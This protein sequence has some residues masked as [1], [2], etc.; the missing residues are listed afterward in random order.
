MWMLPWFRGLQIYL[1][2]FHH[3]GTAEFWRP[4]SCKQ[5]LALCPQWT[6]FENCEHKR[7]ASNYTEVT[8][9]VTG[10]PSVAVCVEGVFQR[11][12]PLQLARMASALRS[13]GKEYLV[14][15]VM[16]GG[17]GEEGQDRHLCKL[18]MRSLRSAFGLK[19]RSL[20]CVVDPTDRDRQFKLKFLRSLPNS[21]NWSWWKENFNHLWTHRVAD[22]VTMA[23]HVQSWT[24]KQMCLQEVVKLERRL[25]ALVDWVIYLRS[26]L[27][28]LAP[29]P[30]LTPMAAMGPGRVWIP[31]VMDWGGL[32]DRWAVMSRDVAPV[33]LGRIR[34]LI[35]GNILPA[36][37]RDFAVTNFSQMLNSEHPINAE[38]ML[39]MSLHYHGI[40]PKR[41]HRFL[42][43]AALHCTAKTKKTLCSERIF[44]ALGP[45]GW[46]DS[47]EFS[48]AYAAASRLQ[49]GWW[50]ALTSP[51]VS[52]ALCERSR[53]CTERAGLG[54]PDCGSSVWSYSHCCQQNLMLSI[55]D[56]SGI[57]ELPDCW[58][59]FSYGFAHAIGRN[60]T[61]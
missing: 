2:L 24:M 49:R 57:R 58:N 36:I 3:L 56:T 31:D 27:D 42:G 60:L 40:W 39:Q 6:L 55:R 12:T 44:T 30:P 32:N 48:D 59:T 52:P 23:G 33:Y 38:R 43:T 29:H 35:D 4:N 37:Q 17:A 45:S 53:C 1:I 26:D 14:V 7:A 5:D 18:A 54:S 46:R 9:N 21:A 13:L 19:M 22:G 51:R 50:W 10:T 8:A 11:T 28:F 34:D 41:V 20:L 61:T 16:T 47:S 15:S 25:P